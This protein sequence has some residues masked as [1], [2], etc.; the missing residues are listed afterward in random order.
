ME[1][2]TI[3]YILLG[4]AYFAINAYTKSQKK[5]AKRQKE[6]EKAQEAR[7]SETSQHPATVP[8]TPTVNPL[9]ELFETFNDDFEEEK[10]PIPI[11]VETQPEIIVHKKA[12]L[13]NPLKDIKSNYNPVDTAPRVSLVNER[14]IEQL[15]E[16]T[17]KRINLLSK[18]QV[19]EPP[20]EEPMD[21]E[22][23]LR[24]AIIQSAILERPKI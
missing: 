20:E 23:D 8:K 12:I 1:P 3:I 4:L 7:K 5:A 14:K 13:R 11:K 2:K 19:V 18:I 6:L 9:K 16:P 10:E 17:R 24:E 21:F 22:F 15:K